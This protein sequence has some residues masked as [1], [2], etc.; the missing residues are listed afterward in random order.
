ML[1]T[2]P[3]T[4]SIGDETPNCKLFTV[5]QLGMTETHYKTSEEEWDR[6]K[7]IIRNLYI[8]ENKT[9]GELMVLMLRDHS[10]RAT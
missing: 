10:F 5:H 9:L 7:D 6:H 8:E 1:S 3:I 2:C 4:G